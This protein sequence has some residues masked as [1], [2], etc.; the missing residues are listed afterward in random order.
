LLLK[1][2]DKFATG[3]DIAEEKPRSVVSKKLMAQIARA[4]GG[5]IEK[6][7]KADPAQ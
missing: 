5:D 1:H 4:A 3:V 7:A 2:R 6:A